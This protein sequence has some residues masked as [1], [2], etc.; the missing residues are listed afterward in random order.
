MTPEPDRPLQP[1]ERLDPRTRVVLAGLFTSATLIA[2][3]LPALL[4]CLA[5]TGALACLARLPLG[6]TLRRLLA[7]EGFMAVVLVT[8]PFTMPGRPLVDVLGF[9]AS[10]EGLAR[11]VAVALKANAVMLAALALLGAM[12]AVVLGQALARLGAPERLV[13]L[14]LFTVRYV[15]VLEREYSRLRLA[16]RARGFR[17]RTGLHC[18]RSLGWLVGMLMVR[19]IERGQRIHA[20]MRCRGFDGRLHLPGTAAPAALDWGV[21]LASAAMLATLAMLGWG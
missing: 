20:A 17:P 3:R 14:L 15:S 9:A 16:M 11:A 8:L 6:P 13:H 4:V 10:A 19:S 18:W 7:L 5:V 21:G 1:L 2:D 12:D